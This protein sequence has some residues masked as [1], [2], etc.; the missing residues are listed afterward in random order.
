ML[1]ITRNC[2]RSNLNTINRNTI[3]RRALVSNKILNQL[4]QSR[5][6]VSYIL[7]DI[8]NNST[9]KIKQGNIKN[10]NV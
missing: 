3:N 1:N 10:L 9:P 4:P 5:S 6:F 2:I 7:K 8:F